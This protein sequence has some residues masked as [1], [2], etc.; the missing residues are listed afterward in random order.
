M[1]IEPGWVMDPIE[2]EL[3]NAVKRGVEVRINYDWVT[4]KFV[5]GDLALLPGIKQ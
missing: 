4:H 2:K 5:N 3:L 1:C